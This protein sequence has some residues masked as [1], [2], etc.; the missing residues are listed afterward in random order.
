MDTEAYDR[1]CRQRVQSVKDLL[2]S[3]L[4]CSSLLVCTI[5]SIPRWNFLRMLNIHEGKLKL[6]CTTKGPVA[7]AIDSSFEHTD[8]IFRGDNQLKRDSSIRFFI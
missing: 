8:E 3:P 2:A 4:F 7:L 6:K 1:K 5:S